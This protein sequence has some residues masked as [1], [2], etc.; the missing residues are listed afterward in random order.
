MAKENAAATAAVATTEVAAP[1]SANVNE[2]TNAVVNKV[3]TTVRS[4]YLNQFGDNK[5]YTLSLWV[6]TKMKVRLMNDAGLYEESTTNFISLPVIAGLAQ[7]NNEVVNYFIAIKGVDIETLKTALSGAEIEC[8]QRLLAAGET[9]GDVTNDKGH[10]QWFTFIK[11]VKIS[12]MA[13]LTMA[14]QLNI[15]V[16]DLKALLEMS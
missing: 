10:D 8:E 6:D 7:I 3:K 14:S 13:M 1:E 4:V 11:K 2:I 5:A 12:R 15:N 16:S 9:S